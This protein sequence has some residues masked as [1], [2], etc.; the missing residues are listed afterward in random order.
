VSRLSRDEAA[1]ALAVRAVEF[2]PPGGPTL[3]L[4]DPRPDVAD[5]ARRSGAAVSTWTRYGGDGTWPEMNREAALVAVR[6]PR[7]RRELEMLLHMAAGA[8]RVGGRLLIYGANDEGIKSAPGRVGPLFARPVTLATGGHARLI[9][10]WRDSA[11]ATPRCR[12]LDW[13]SRIEVTILGR[14]RP[15][16]SYPGVFAHDRVDEGTALLLEHLPAIAPEGR[17]LDY[18]AGTGVIAAGVLER[19]PTARVTALEPDGLA[20]AAAAENVP[21]ARVRIGRGWAALAETEPWDLVVSNPPYH[22][23]KAETLAEIESF[24][25]G[26]PARLA[27]GGSIRCVVQRRLPFGERAQDAGLSRT[28]IVAD[29]GPYRIWDA[30]P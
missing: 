1:S 3:V 2:D 16:V 17:V 9:E 20:A 28:R 29:R 7:A 25:A 30:A 8:L 14:T 26:V 4:E 18:G 19:S 12:A 13:M 11:E 24:L 23:G 6:L 22:R 10:A 15:W 21:G 5:A 27:R